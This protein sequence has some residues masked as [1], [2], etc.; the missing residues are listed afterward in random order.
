[1]PR[2][3]NDVEGWNSR[4][5]KVITKP[6]PNIF[7]WI[8]FIQREEVVTKDKIQS[9]TSV[10]TAWPRRRCMKEKEL[11]VQAIFEREGS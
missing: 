1:M 3:N 2:N 11:R 6:H 5:T 8:E 9:F 4:M 7:A 10:A